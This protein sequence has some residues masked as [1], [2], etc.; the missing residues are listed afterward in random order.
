MTA[1]AAVLASC[2]ALSAVASAFAASPQPPQTRVDA[3][4]ETHFGIVV[5]DRYRWLEA[6][7]DDR[8]I[9]WFKAQAD[10]TRA[11]LDGLP[12]RARLRARIAELNGADTRVTDAQWGG[13]DLFY[14]KR[15]P[16]D[17]VFKLYVRRG[18]DGPERLL[19]DPVALAGGE[20]T[21]AIDYHRPSPNGKRTAIGISTGGSENTTML[22]FDVAT[23]AMLGTPVLRAHDA[24]PSWRFDSNVLF[25]RQLKQL[26][27]G[28]PPAETF[29]DSQAYMRT[30]LPS[31]PVVDAPVLGRGLS[32]AVELAPDDAPAVVVSPVSPYAI[33][34]VSHGVE[35]EV[36]LYVAPLAQVRGAATPWRKLAGPERAITDID[37]RG[38]WIYLLTH[39]GAPRSRIVR[40]SLR[41]PARFDPERAEVVLAQGDRVIHGLGVSKDALY[42]QQHDAGVG[43]LLRLEFNVG[44]R[45]EPRRRGARTERQPARSAASAAPRKTA[46]VARNR[47]VPLPYA[48]AIQERIT[49]PL[50]PGAL[51]RLAGWTHAPA[52]YLVDGRGG[53][54]AKTSL[55]PS[56]VADFGAVSSVQV[57]VQSHDGTAVPLTIVY[58]RNGARNG[59][60]PLLLEAYG[61]YGHVVEPTFWPTLLAWLERGGVYAVA[62]VRGGGELGKPW[63]LAGRRATKANSWRDLVAC[64]DYLVR[65]RWASPS[66]LAGLAAS[67]GGIALMNAVIDRPDL[68]AAVVSQSGFHDPLRSETGAAGPA[69]A[70]EFGTVSTEDGFRDLLAMSPYEKLRDGVRYPAALFTTGF[71][72]V[73]VDPWDPGK[74]AARMQAVNASDGGS[75]KP[76][77]LRVDFGAGHGTTSTREQ[78]IDEYADILA[79]LDAAL[80]ER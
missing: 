64:A 73:R 34:V 60:A 16:R 68:F 1:R 21:A 3:V 65:E 51:L 67:A 15:G 10:H 72:D 26:K 56:P 2:I 63:H 9:A 47:E 76:V 31:G 12:G 62:H 7:A 45:K 18:L 5:P 4:Q 8:V 59:T 39:E 61:A 43:R 52:Y 20:P 42:V 30:F 78:T 6:T 53:A 55:M 36:S 75:G 13:D 14:L 11:V 66:R 23:M 50:R 79:F 69:N 41:D 70:T 38:E 33:G 54:P 74:M 77:L 71:N 25:F 27:E 57:R 29:R 37:L 48:G 46:G 49:D 44:A 58:P 28:D 22:V 40:W 19:V 24:S 32:S 17:E 80:A 35:R